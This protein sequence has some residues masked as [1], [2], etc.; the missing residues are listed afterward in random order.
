[1]FLYIFSKKYGHNE[2]RFCMIVS[3]GIILTTYMPLVSNGI[4]LTSYMPL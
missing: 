1:M 4:I 3:N 2:M